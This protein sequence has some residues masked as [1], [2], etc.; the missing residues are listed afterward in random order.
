MIKYLLARTPF[1]HVL[2]ILI[3]NSTEMITQ[4][5]LGKDG[6]GFVH[7]D[8]TYTI[9]D[10]SFHS[11]TG[12]LVTTTISP[13]HSLAKVVLESHIRRNMGITL[14]AFLQELSDAIEDTNRARQNQ[15]ALVNPS[16]PP[17]NPRTT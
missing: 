10:V 7:N 11:T 17:E 13:E 1:F 5:A 16:Y 4:M 8:Q 9:S 3:Q 12:N 14:A 2:Q 6:I 15:A